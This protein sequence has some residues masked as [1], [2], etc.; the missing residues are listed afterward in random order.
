MFFYFIFVIGYFLFNSETF[1]LNLKTIRWHVVFKLREIRNTRISVHVGNTNVLYMPTRRPKVWPIGSQGIN[2]TCFSASKA[3]SALSSAPTLISPWCAWEA[4][5]FFLSYVYSYFYSYFNLTFIITT[6]LIVTHI[7]IF[8]IILLLFFYCSS[9]LLG[10]LYNFKSLKEL[11]SNRHNSIKLCVNDMDTASFAD[12]V[13][14]AFVAGNPL[15]FGPEQESKTDKC[16]PYRSLRIHTTFK[17][18]N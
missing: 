10:P 4:N 17:F 2:V 15:G 11:L 6:R 1:F 3:A 8:I 16:Y 7:V 5:A 12:A 9:G 13:R 18:V 14:P